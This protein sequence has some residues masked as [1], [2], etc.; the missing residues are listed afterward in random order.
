ML[1]DVRASLGLLS[2]GP[3]WRGAAPIPLA[4]AAAAAEAVGA[5]AAFGLITILGDPTRAAALP[6]A[7]WVYPHLPAHDNRAIV[8]AFTL[9]VI[10][11]YVARNVLLAGVTWAQERA[12]NAS[13]AELSNRLRGLPRR[14]LR[15]PLPA[16]LR[17]VDSP[18]DRRGAQ[19]LPRCARLARRHRHRGAGGAGARGRPRRDRAGRHA[20]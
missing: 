19:R 20:G 1:A 7:A 18:R 15:F 3:R 2:P 6:V 14:A 11:F 17:S 5:G 10:G 13:V 8:L 16:Q 4:L 9:L 12:L